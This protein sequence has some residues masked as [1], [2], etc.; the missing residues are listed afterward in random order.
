M[1]YRKFISLFIFILALLIIPKNVFAES[2]F[3]K[4]LTDGKLV[5]NSIQPSNSN[6][7][8]AVVYE[9]T[10][11][12]VDEKYYLDWDTSFNSDCSEVTIYYGNHNTGDP[13]VTVP[14][15]YTYDKDIKKVIDSLVSA[16]ED[17]DNI[18]LNEIEFINYLLNETEDSSMANYSSEF[19]KSLGYKNFSIDIRLGD[20]AP[21]YTEKGGNALFSYDGTVYYIRGMMFTSAKH[22]IYVDD[23]TTDILATVK[24]RLNKIFG[25]DFDIV[26]KDTVENFLESE[27]Q[28]R[29]NMYNTQTYLHA[30]FATAEDYATYS[31]NG[32]YYDDDALYHY[33][34]EP[35]VYEKYY[36]LTINGNKV[37]FL[38]AKDSSKVNDDVKLI[39]SDVGSDITVSTDSLIPLDTLIKVS[40]IT[41][42][43]EY[44]KIIKILNIANGE[45]FNLQ[46]FSSSI[47]DYITELDNG[48]FEVKM[49]VSENLKDK[50]LIV[51][52]VKGDN[53]VEE[54]EVKV[55]DG[56]AVFTTD[57]FSIYTLAPKTSTSTATATNTLLNPPTGDNIVM[58]VV[59][60][61]LSIVGLIKSGLYLR[62]EMI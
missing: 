49:P 48:T 32:L 52:Y 9:N 44:E 57:H 60:L 18:P 47:G 4:L 12:P 46:L 13:S 38:V 2:V 51:Y 17:V 37:K 5:V 20:D 19:R 27:R 40:K 53:S 35:N 29:V 23:D 45:M 54:H 6:D 1:R 58:Y 15:N 10:I 28:E 61:V 25:T 30:G 26:E 55:V 36:E 34:V 7:A 22:I 41:S 42:G 3:D 11:M 33:V 39:T 8:Y 31:M 16:I 50:D 43:E 24:A 59:I 14:I 56:Y 21:F 62:K